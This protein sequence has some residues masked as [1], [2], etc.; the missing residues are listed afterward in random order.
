MFLVVLV[1]PKTNVYV[2]LDMSATSVSFVNQTKTGTVWLQMELMRVTWTLERVK[3]SY[4]HVIFQNQYK[5][6][7][8]KHYD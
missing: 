3:E 6:Y 2:N 4:A 1:A 8:S 5:P 7:K